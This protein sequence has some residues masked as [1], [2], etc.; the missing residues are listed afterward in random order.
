MRVSKKFCEL[1]PPFLRIVTPLFANCYPLF[2]ELLPP[3]FSLFRLERG[4]SEKL[5][6]VGGSSLKGSKCWRMVTPLFLISPNG[7]KNSNSE[8]ERVACPAPALSPLLCIC[9]F[10]LRGLAFLPLFCLFYPLRFPLKSGGLV[11]V[12]L[13]ACFY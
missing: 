10:L 11:W 1:L 9:F 2:C 5:Y 13:P 4:V 12:Q 3:S 7:A 8:K 6:L